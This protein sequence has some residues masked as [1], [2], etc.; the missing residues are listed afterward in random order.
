M[1]EFSDFG[2][3]LVSAGLMLAMFAIFGRH[4][5]PCR[6]MA[7]ALCIFLALRYL[8][9]HLTLGMPKGQNLLQQAWAWIFFFFE[10]MN[11]L[12]S[13]IVCFFMSRNKDRSADA[14]AAQNSPLLAAPVDVFYQVSLITTDRP[15]LLFRWR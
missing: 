4:S 8:W 12:S 14:D 3:P 5:K 6:A 9:W 2:P 13:I 1:I 7:S 11:N 15:T 10:A